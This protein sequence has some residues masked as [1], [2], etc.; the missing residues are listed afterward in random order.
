MKRFL[1]HG[2]IMLVSVMFVA[3][4]Q[5]NSS[6]H[7]QCTVCPSSDQWLSPTGTPQLTGAFSLL[8]SGCRMFEVYM[9]ANVT[10]TF[11]T[12]SNGA[13]FTDDPVMEILNSA[14]TQVAYNDDN[15]GWGSEI[16]YTPTT[17]GTYYLRARGIGYSACSMNIAYWRNSG[18]CIACPS[19]DFDL[20]PSTTPQ[21]TGNFALLPDG[22]RM[23]RT[24]MYANTTY[25]F[26][27]CSNG[28]SYTDDTVFEILDG[29][30]TN[31]A[32]SDDFCSLGS[33][34]SY[35]P[36]T[37]GYHYFRARGFGYSACSM[38]VAYWRDPGV[39]VVCP[40][41]D[42][43]I[44][45]TYV[46]QTHSSGVGIGGCKKYEMN[47]TAGVEYVFTF[48]DGGGSA[49]YD[50]YLTLLNSTCAQVAT[51]D[52]SYCG[53]SSH[54]VYTAP[55]TGTYYL[56][57]NSCCIGG[58]GGN[59]TLAYKANCTSSD[60]C[61]CATP[62]TALPFNSGVVS[63]V[64]AT[65][66]TLPSSGCGTMGSTLWYTI[67]G[68]GNRM[69]LSTC[70]VA[71][72]FDTEIR[73]FTG[74]C[75]A[76][77]E[78][79]CNDDNCASYGLA[80]TVEFCSTLGE[81]YQVAVGCYA[82][83]GCTGNFVFTA[84]DMPLS[85]PNPIAGTNSRCMGAGTDTYISSAAN[86]EFLIWEIN[87]PSAGSIVSSTGVVTWDPLFTGPAT[88]SVSGSACG[89]TSGPVT[90]IVDVLPLP[91][92]AG[93]I[94]GPAVVCQ[95]ATGE[96]YSITAVANAVSYVWQYSGS[97]ATINGTTESVTI[98]FS[99]SATSGILTV[100]AQNACGNGLVS[101]N[102]NIMV[103]NCTEIEEND[104][105][106]FQVLPNPST[107]Y[108]NVVYNA[109]T[110]GT[111]VFKLYNELSQLVWSSET[112]FNAGENTMSVD[113]EHLPAGVYYLHST[114][115]NGDQMQKLIIQ[116]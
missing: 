112:K 18:V 21:T 26:S 75:A 108:F 69:R 102:F 29:T 95:E 54:M 109:S 90:Y 96:A 42:F 85:A 28:G 6:V 55:T 4:I 78:V 93:A 79:A 33:Q 10:Y 87:P 46:F 62:I 107:G 71:T 80:S 39:C 114:D 24:Y 61:L 20:Y 67:T 104:N 86:S 74:G 65:N 27:V 94:N 7:A 17:S 44:T 115:E 58:T 91:G 1:H 11:T 103:N 2:F 63:N 84:E 89:Q 51:N 47:L 77:T 41:F 66:E 40:A 19:F 113:L 38:N 72:N 106:S 35:T 100:Y 92:A 101:A 31:V 49:T 48:C 5:V 12:C 9:Y 81:I 30:C 83:A 16:V 14:C 50:T 25:N 116:K 53:L 59:Y 15:C 34:I 105:L 110:Q 76:L 98:D 88:I 64:G 32:Y 99:A 8:S 97:G 52:D 82:V 23:Y 56:E 13:T 3:A 37:T 22:C 45:P 60:D 111:V 36:T 73:V 57:V 43:S 70:D 68:T